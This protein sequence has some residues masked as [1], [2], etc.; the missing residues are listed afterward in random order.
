ML[1][2]IKAR[3]AEYELLTD[4]FKKVDAIHKFCWDFTDSMVYADLCKEKAEQAQEILKN[5]DY[6]LGKADN[7]SVMSHY[8]WSKANH[9]KATEYG[10]ASIELYRKLNET[11]SLSHTLTMLAF[12]Y[13]SNGDY[14]E[15]FKLGFEARELISAKPSSQYVA[16][17]YYCL[18]VL[19]FDT[20]DF[21]SSLQNV[22]QAKKLAEEMGF[23]YGL[24]RSKTSL[25]ALALAK[26]NYDEARKHLASAIEGFREVGHDIGLSRALNDLGVI[27]RKL[28]DYAEAEKYLKESYEIRSVVGHTQGITTTAF[29]LG[30]LMNARKSPDEALKWL[31]IALGLAVKTSSR[32]KE[33]QIHKAIAE[34]YRLSNKYEK[35]YEHLE[36][37]I[38]IQNSV[39]GQETAQKLKHLQTRIATE[40]AEKEA[41]IERLKNVELKQAHDIIADKNKEIVDSINYAWRIQSALLTSDK[42]LKENL[43]EYFVLFKPK[44]I[45]SGDFYWSTKHADRSYVAVCDSTGHGVPG[46][47]MSIL[48]T[49]YMNEAINEKGIK[50]PNEVFNHVRRRLIENISQDGQQDGMD[51]ILLCIE[52]DTLTYAAAHNAPVL[53]SKAGIEELGADKMPVG[54][55]EKADSF[56]LHKVNAKKGDMLYLYTDGYA[57][58]FGGPNG[59]KFKY[60]QLEE[61]LLAI[62]QWPLAEQKKILE[63][64][65][66][67]WQGNLE[68]IDDVLVVG[69]RL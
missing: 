54:K 42:L 52:N 58:Q 11:E 68:Q 53:I 40:K 6:P 19:Y 47:F 39:M 60:K 66:D 13:A 31:N 9:A 1:N 33:Y 65:F 4:P 44:D 38:E 62:S 63:R 37:Y 18:G 12:S 30:E 34:A 10:N 36:K 2:R 26:G 56:K 7:L 17:I 59:K 15:A 16:W 57:D 24:A 23:A 32:S 61:K 28:G 67:E 45:V 20:K 35:A 49:S 8:Y 3:V 21:D 22:L 50:E 5:I 48:N 25:A 51:G 64:T 46:A 14:D 69:I 55:G 43:S 41:E 27:C 29:E